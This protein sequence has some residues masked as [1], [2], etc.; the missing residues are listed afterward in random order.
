M[1]DNVDFEAYLERFKRNYPSIEMIP[2]LRIIM[3]NA[4]WEGAKSQLIKTFSDLKKSID[5]DE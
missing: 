2:T 4:F 5:T 1:I 3:E